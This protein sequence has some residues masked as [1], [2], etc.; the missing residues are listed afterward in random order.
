M[1]VGETLNSTGIAGTYFV[2]GSPVEG[3]SL[4]L[5]VNKR[6]SATETAS[7]IMLSLTP[8]PTVAISFGVAVMS[9]L[10]V[11]LQMNRAFRR[12]PG[13]GNQ[14]PDLARLLMVLVILFVGS[15]IA[16]SVSQ[17][18]T[19]PEWR[20]TLLQGFVVV[21]GS[22]ALMAFPVWLSATGV[23]GSWYSGQRTSARRVW[24]DPGIWVIAAF[25]IAVFGVSLFALWHRLNDAERI[26]QLAYVL[27]AIFFTLEIAAAVVVRIRGWWTSSPRS[28]SR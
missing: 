23:L 21:P 4:W 5:A 3:R 26:A 7:Q 1:R 24:I 9:V 10:I 27:L 12:Y 11:V 16:V 2:N 17:S 15:L 20:N 18:P 22:I 25:N 19:P 14:V 28:E 6:L 8:W 13:V